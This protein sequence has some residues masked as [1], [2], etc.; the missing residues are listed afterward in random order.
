MWPWRPWGAGG[1]EGEKAWGWGAVAG[2]ALGRLVGPGCLCWPGQ[3]SVR[4]VGTHRMPDAAAE[5]LSPGLVVWTEADG[6]PPHL[7]VAHT[8]TPHHSHRCPQATHK[9]QSTHIIAVVTIASILGATAPPQ[10]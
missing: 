8:A 2:G 9:H 6:T 3:S 7:P 1:W 10:P 5:A 4:S